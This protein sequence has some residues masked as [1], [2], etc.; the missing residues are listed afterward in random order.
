MPRYKLSPE[1]RAVEKTRLEQLTTL[2]SQFYI[3]G[4]SDF[5]GLFMEMVGVF[6][7]HTEPPTLGEAPPKPKNLIHRQRF[8]LAYYDGNN[9]MEKDELIHSDDKA[10]YKSKSAGKNKV[11]LA[12]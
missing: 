5:R 6:L 3:N 9:P 12:D 4:V 7:I 10:L 11:T 8:G 2:M 1:E